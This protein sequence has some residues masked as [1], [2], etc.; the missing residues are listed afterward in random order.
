[1]PP[2]LGDQTTID[3]SVN[4][5]LHAADRFYLRAM[6]SYEV[7]CDGEVVGCINN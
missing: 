7:N 1:M 6:Q 2:I 5:T 4:S 3:A